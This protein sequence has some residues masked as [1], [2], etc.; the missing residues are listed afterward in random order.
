LFS[1]HILLVKQY[2]ENKRF[3]GPV[4]GSPGSGMEIIRDRK[5]QIQDLFSVIFHNKFLSFSK[6]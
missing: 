1:Y 4:P 2:I 6:V 3:T 5:I